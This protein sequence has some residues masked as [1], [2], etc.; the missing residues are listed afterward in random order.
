VISTSGE[1]KLSIAMMN[2]PSIG[3]DISSSDD[4][5]DMHSVIM[6]QDKLELLITLLC[7]DPVLQPLYQEARTKVSSEVLER[8]RR[9]LLR[10]FAVELQKEVTTLWE[11]GIGEFVCFRARNCA[12]MICSSLDHNRP[13]PTRKRLSSINV[14]PIAIGDNSDDSCEWDSRGN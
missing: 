4:E 3:G 5:P 14:P 11:R 10:R 12:Q 13:N 1:S 9:S 6:A 8:K 7:K 2:S